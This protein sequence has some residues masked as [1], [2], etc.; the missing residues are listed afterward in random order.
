[1]SPSSQRTSPK[2]LSPTRTL[3]TQSPP[4]RRKGLGWPAFVLALVTAGALGHVA[5]RLHSLELSYDLARQRKVESALEEQ[6]RRLH[7]EIGMLKD[8]HRVVAL[9]GDRL[10]MGPPAPED[11]RRLR[12]GMSFAPLTA[13]RPD[14]AAVGGPGRASGPARG[15]PLRPSRAVT[16]PPAELPRPARSPVGAASGAAKETAGAPGLG[17]A[18]VPAAAPLAGHAR[19]KA[20]APPAAE[21]PT[22]GSGAAETRP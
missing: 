8:P 13:T 10:Q 9:A 12:R 7:T 4:P 17:L 14:G 15:G 19:V 16:K 5:L 6:K 18:T 20:P 3:P 1:M 22:G 11:I 21:E 2:R